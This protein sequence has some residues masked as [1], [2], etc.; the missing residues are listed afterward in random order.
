MRPLHSCGG[1]TA[2]A[3][4][5]LTV[6]V[7]SARGAWLRA[8]FTA[9]VSALELF[10]LGK[11]DT[12]DRA[13]ALLLCGRA[14]LR[15]QRAPEAKQLLAPAI[16]T[17]CTN[18]AECTARMLYAVA[19]TRCDSPD[20]G[21]A[22]LR[23]AAERADRLEVHRA[24]RLEI[25]YYR[26]LSYWAKRELGAVAELAGRVEDARLDVL[27]VRA[28]Q[29]LGFVAIAEQRY[30][31]ALRTFRLALQAYRACRERDTDLVE[32]ILVQI[33]T[34]E[35]QLRSATVPGSYGDPAA[36]KVAGDV[37]RAAT[38]LGRSQIAWLDAWQF[39]HDGDARS[40]LRCMREAECMAPTQPAKVFALA[41]RASI[42]AAF[43]E[44]ENA[45]EQALHAARMAEG[46]DWPATR[47][48]E[49]FALLQ[50]VEAFGRVDPSEAAR[51]LARFD[52]IA[53][54][55]DDVLLA[56]TDPR[57]AALESYARGIVA[58]HAGQTTRA[59]VLLNEAYR[60]FLACG[61][62]WRA[63]LALIE[64]DA[65]FAAS[66]VHEE[67]HLETAALIVREH[68]PNS[69]LARRLGRWAGLYGHPIGVRLTPAQRQILRY[70]LEGYGAKE[71]ASVT[72]RSVKTIGNQLAS[73]H[74]AFGVNS[75]LRLV[76]ECH[77]L[78]FG[79]PSWGEPALVAVV[80][81]VRA[82]DRIAG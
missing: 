44:I 6:S 49:R 17:F 55:V 36:R 79:S 54:K 66:D 62:L 45:R 52:A 33:A 80:P 72:G 10:E 58:R 64:L 32:Q 69:F 2:D 76:A 12:P 38:S 30:G 35:A 29:L 57:P 15:S 39:A 75:T 18:D 9:C 81:P 51:V 24:V 23:A 77:R 56:G 67:F 41:G 4:S 82:A 1:G 42:S 19:V 59:R 13:E 73:L 21:L 5:D 43:G 70:A 37:F 50:L 20:D 60:G 11:G 7:A 34:L 74:Q 3:A 63:V 48:E 78:G 71:I 65:A 26:A 46:I 47:G 28:T 53:S 61:H 68:F 8:D 25:A 16:G 22:L 27:S 40:A 31:D 14:L